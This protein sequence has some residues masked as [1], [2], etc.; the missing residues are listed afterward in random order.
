M[1]ELCRY[2]RFCS[3]ISLTIS[4]IS[5]NGAL[6]RQRV[7]GDSLEYETGIARQSGLDSHLLDHHTYVVQCDTLRRQG[8]DM[9]GVEP[10]LIY[11]DWHLDT[12]VLGQVGDQPGVGYIAIEAIDLTA[13]EG[14]DDVGCVLVASFKADGRVFGEPLLR[15]FFQVESSSR[16]P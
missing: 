5:A 10:L 11:E 9:Y 6:R 1:L 16:I 2:T 3:S 14:I 15:L 13:L 8:A 12:G 7:V 4:L